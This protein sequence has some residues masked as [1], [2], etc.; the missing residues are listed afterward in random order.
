M[1]RCRRS[2]IWV[3]AMAA[4]RPGLAVLFVLPL[5]TAH[6]GAQLLFPPTVAALGLVL[7]LR[8]AARQLSPGPT[9]KGTLVPS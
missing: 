5:F 8:Q 7:A 9:A 4:E 1:A 3:P 6:T 2:Q